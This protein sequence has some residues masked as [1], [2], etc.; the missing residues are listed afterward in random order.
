MYISLADLCLTFHYSLVQL[1]YQTMAEDWLMKVHSFVWE[2]HSLY[3]SVKL[4][5]LLPALQAVDTNGGAKPVT[6]QVIEV[7][8]P[9][10]N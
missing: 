5:N 4:C 3:F 8:E 10:G 6:T 9:L 2:P 1:F 7:R